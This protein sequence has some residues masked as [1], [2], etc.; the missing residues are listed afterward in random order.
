MV[1]LDTLRRFP[2]F[3]ELSENELKEIASITTQKSFPAQHQIFAEGDDAKYLYVIMKGRVEIDYT[4]AEDRHLNI[5]TLED[6]DIL[7]WSALVEPYKIKAVGTTRE[8]TLVL[9]I[10]AEKL[11]EILEVDPIL[12][13]VLMHQVSKMLGERL[14]IARHKFARLYQSL[15]DILQLSRD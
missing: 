5:Q 3:S 14:Q 4:L 11:R 1:D 12:A 13:H 6:G 9:A 7:V 15:D 10:D 8:N 2:Y